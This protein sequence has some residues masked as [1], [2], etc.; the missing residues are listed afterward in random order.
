LKYTVKDEDEH[1]TY[2]FEQ[3]TKLHEVDV[4]HR[5]LVDFMRLDPAETRWLVGKTPL[6]VSACVGE[7]STGVFVLV[8]CAL[9]RPFKFFSLHQSMIFYQSFTCKGTAPKKSVSGCGGLCERRGG[10]QVGKHRP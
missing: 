8:V 4:K 3:K 9:K 5:H 10:G 1:Q 6:A 2:F 7:A